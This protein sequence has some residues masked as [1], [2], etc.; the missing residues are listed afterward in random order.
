VN[1]TLMTADLFNMFVAFEVMLVSSYALLTLETDDRRIRRAIPYLK[2]NIIGSTLFL[3]ACGLTYGWLGTLDLGS[4]SL[5]LEQHRDDPRTAWLA[6]LLLLV[7]GIKSAIFPL[8]Y[9][10]PRSYPALPPA[11][12]ALFGGLLTKIGIYVMIRLLVTVFPSGLGSV[13]GVL[14]PL[15]AITMVLGGLGAISRSSIRSI[16]SWH[17]VSQIGFM[18]T[19]LALRSTL[20]ITAAIAIA[21]HNVLVKSSLLLCGGTIR[22]LAGTDE[23]PRIGHLARVAPWLAVVFF[24]QALSL[25]G[26]PPLSGFWGKLM[27]FRAGFD[28]TE[29]VVLAAAAVAGFLTLASM[30][31]IWLGAFWGGTDEVE[32]PVPDRS[33]RLQTALAGVLVVAAL[34]IG[35]GAEGFLGAA[36]ASAEAAQDRDGYVRI[37][38][39]A[40]PGSADSDSAAGGRTP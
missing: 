33:H 17:I 22:R 7:V 12:A 26:L 10:L 20:A 32:A 2:I 19:A 18:V 13:D 28:A 16:L 6:A 8:F 39:G 14:L 40:A 3:A 5:G 4:V 35:I 34:A 31:K 24:L 15:A 25:A 9:W 27:L 37:L 1:L 11:L 36:R 23:L 29:W 30:L 21:L 38:R